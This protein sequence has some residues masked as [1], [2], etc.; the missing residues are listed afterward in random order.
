M[1][2][3]TSGQLKSSYGL[4][5]LFVAWTEFG[6]QSYLCASTIHSHLSNNILADVKSTV[7]F[8]FFL[9]V[10]RLLSPGHLLS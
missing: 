2:S 9:D 6:A 8:F 3:L 5:D 7:L 1:D 10:F 4:R